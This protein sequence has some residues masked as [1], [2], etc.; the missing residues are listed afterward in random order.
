MELWCLHRPWETGQ[1]LLCVEINLGA[2]FSEVGEKRGSSQS[3]A[4]SYAH[5]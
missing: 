4:A 5:L 3:Y 2:T 1:A